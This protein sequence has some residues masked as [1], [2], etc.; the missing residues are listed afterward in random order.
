[1][2]F[3]RPCIW[4]SSMSACVHLI[5][6][7]LQW[8][9]YPNRRVDRLVCTLICSQTAFLMECLMSFTSGFHK[10]CVFW[11]LKP[12][13]WRTDTVTFHSSPSTE[14]MN[15]IWEKTEWFPFMWRYPHP[16]PP[17][18]GFSLWFFDMFPTACCVRSNTFCCIVCLGMGALYHPLMV[19]QVVVRV[20]RNSRSLC[21]L[22]TKFR[23]SQRVC[24]EEIIVKTFSH[25][26]CG[27]LLTDRM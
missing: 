23:S 12:K 10:T 27:F 17:L 3:A 16:K 8:T 6:G 22:W 21:S 4:S 24:F 25:S 1:M 26:R 11:F 9:F 20:D 19:L 14:L 18:F 15:H 5:L 2:C 13:E 7:T